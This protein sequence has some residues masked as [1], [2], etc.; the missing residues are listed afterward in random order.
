MG[1]KHRVGDFV[2]LRIGSRPP[3]K[4]MVVERLKDDFYLLDWGS[5]GFNALLNTVK[6][7]G[8]SLM[9]EGE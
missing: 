5:C 3:M 7:S 6:I 1:K 2:W 9:L 4:I 8:K